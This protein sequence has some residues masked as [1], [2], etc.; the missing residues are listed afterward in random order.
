MKIDKN[1]LNKGIML[2]NLKLYNKMALAVFFMFIMPVLL[3]IYLIFLAPGII[4]DKGQLLTHE[5]IIIIQMGVCGIFG[6]FFMRMTIKKLIGIIKKAENLSSA[7]NTGTI[8]VTGNDELKGLA[9]SFNKV[10]SAL[11]TK[12][13]E[14]QY[15]Q[16]LTRELFQQMG[17][18][19][20]SFQKIEALLAVIVHGMRKVLEVSSS[21]IALYD[22]EGKLCLKAYAGDRE[23]LSD[24]MI[25]PD[26]SGIMG[27]LIKGLRPVIVNKDSA[28]A[29]AS[30]SNGV[31]D[32]NK[33]IV[34]VPILVRGTIRG[35]LG[36]TDK[37]SLRAMGTE[38]VAL[39]ESV[40]SQVAICVENLELSK[41]IEETYY[42]T[43]VML[44]RIVEARDT[45]SAGHLERV[46]SYMQMFADKLEIEE[47]TKKVLIGGALLHDLGK[48]GIADSILKKKGMLT[49]DEYQTM[50]QHSVIGENIL[51]PLRSM[52]K[53]SDMVRHHH[54]MYDGTGYPDGLKGE[55]IP[56]ASRILAVI[57]IYDAITTDRSY[58]DLMSKDEAI[59]TLRS[60]AG[61]KLDPELVDVFIELVTEKKR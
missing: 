17:R 11:E 21:F 38:D 22:D 14:L 60:Y 2:E 6:Y 26:G 19:M 3:T 15:S 54:E 53:L 5:R 50:K 18:A 57:D 58:R 55:E 23:D 33:S 1:I 4:P 7:A 46:F 44:A 59:K 45:Y 39:L 40:A 52:S 8:E 12:I 36:A 13:K 9:G 32:Y 47:E 56:L 31:M 34:C 49:A 48:V 35:V 16:N 41:N 24:N 37:V 43:L 28:D 10:K 51:K 27:D 20:T 30:T 61:N 25:L 29:G 42:N